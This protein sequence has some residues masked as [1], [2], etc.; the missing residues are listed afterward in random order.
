MILNDTIK[1]NGARYQSLI[2]SNFFLREFLVF[3]ET[4]FKFYGFGC[5]LQQSTAFM[6]HIIFYTHRP[7]GKNTSYSG[8]PAHESKAH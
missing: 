3:H 2:A 6:L 5:P 4:F 8:I 7:V 1:N